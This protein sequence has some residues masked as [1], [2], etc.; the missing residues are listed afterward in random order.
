MQV[1]VRSRVV[2]EGETGLIAVQ[3]AN[4]QLIANQTVLPGVSIMYGWNDDAKGLTLEAR[5]VKAWYKRGQIEQLKNLLRKDISCLRLMEGICHIYGLRV[6]YDTSTRTVSL[7]P[8]YPVTVDNISIPGFYANTDC[9]DFPYQYVSQPQVSII[10]SERP[11]RIKLSFS[12]SDDNPYEWSREEFDSQLEV[13]TYQSANPLFVAAENITVLMPRLERVSQMNQYV[14]PIE[15]YAAHLVNAGEFN[16][17][18]GPTYEV[19]PIIARYYG[20]ADYVF[21]AAVEGVFA[22][23]PIIAGLALVSIPE[24]QTTLSRQV[25]MFE[26]AYAATLPILVIT[27]SGNAAGTPLTY[28]Q[29]FDLLLRRDLLSRYEASELIASVEMTRT[30]AQDFDYRKRWS[31][32]LDGRPIETIAVACE[33][34]DGYSSNV[35]LVAIV[36]DPT[37]SDEVSPCQSNSAQVNI[38]VNTANRTASASFVVETG[39]NEID[40]TVYEYRRDGGT[41]TTYTPGQ[42]LAFVSGQLEFRVTVSFT[43]VC[44]DLVATSQIDASAYSVALCGGTPGITVNLNAADNWVEA[45][46]AADM[47]EFSHLNEFEVS[48]DGEP[49]ETYVAGTRIENFSE[50]IFRRRGQVSAD[51][52]VREFTRVV[53]STDPGVTNPPCSA[54]PSLTASVSGPGVLFGVDATGVPG[55]IQFQISVLQN[56][57]TRWVDFNGVPVRVAGKV[58]L[59]TRYTSGCP[60]TFKMYSYTLAGQLTPI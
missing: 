55:Q 3:S 47:V 58:A 13:Q 7:L 24:R 6:D 56:N 30:Q 57:A 42:A 1:H 46:P 14:A 37:I 35:R 32:L 36:D 8:S 15:V 59:I 33:Q 20:D 44:A 48:V 21:P 41:W 27:P 52:P 53:T 39:D 18:D 10:P 11:D 40:Q 54:Q 19:D 34:V 17:T 29:Y 43:G 23:S 26:Q 2:P 28:G 51:C 9:F 49:Y 16:D 12:G 25:D 45:F 38:S 4:N 50:V 60:D 5:C 31:V 22:P